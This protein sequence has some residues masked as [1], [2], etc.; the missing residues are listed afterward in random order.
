MVCLVV[1]ISGPVD[2]LWANYKLKEIE[3]IYWSKLTL[4]T[5]ANPQS[6]IQYFLA[7]IDSIKKST[8]FSKLYIKSFNQYS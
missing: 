7:A 2:L 3:E 8:L 5:F 1:L 6:S 4:E